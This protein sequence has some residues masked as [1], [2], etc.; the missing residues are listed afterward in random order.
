MAFPGVSPADGVDGRY[1]VVVIGGG[2]AG[3]AAAEPGIGQAMI[4]NQATIENVI[5][6]AYNTPTYSY[7]Y[8]LAAVDTLTL[9]HPDVLQRMR[10]PSEA[11]RISAGRR[12][13]P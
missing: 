4:H 11:H 7:G 10:L 5:R 3:E 8:K 6:T 13:Q 2:P 9:L 1:D 12:A